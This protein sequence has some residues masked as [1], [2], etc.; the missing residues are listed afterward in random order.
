MDENGN[1]LADPQK[2]LNR[3][4]NI[5]NRV[6]NVHRV[7]SIRQ[8]DIQRAEPLVPEPSIFEVEIATG[9]LRCYKSP[10]TDQ[11]PAEFIKSG[12]EMLYFEIHKII[13]SIWNKEEIPQH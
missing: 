10:G 7:H 4:K 1:L 3:W 12:C 11:I 8:K 6:L 5:F 13:C 9:K 2:I